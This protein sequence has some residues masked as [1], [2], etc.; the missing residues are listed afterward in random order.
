MTASNLRPFVPSG[1][2]YA[3]AKRF[4][5]SIGFKIEFD[6]GDVAGLRCGDVAFLLQRYENRE[7]QQ[8]LMLAFDVPDLDAWWRMLE[9]SGALALPGVRARPPQQFPWGRREVHVVDPAG[10]CWHVGEARA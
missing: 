4:F 3:L 2:D 8:N 5:E 6:A 10:V 9:A 1:A 7:M